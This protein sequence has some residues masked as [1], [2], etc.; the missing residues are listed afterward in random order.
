MPLTVSGSTAYPLWEPGERRVMYLRFEQDGFS[1]RSVL[2]DGGGGDEEVF[3]Y[4]RAR[5]VT[6]FAPEGQ[7]GVMYEVNPTTNRDIW[8]WS[9]TDEPQVLFNSMFNERAPVISPDGKYF[10]YISDR[11]GQD[12]IYVTSFPDAKGR[13]L[14]SSDGGTEP[15]WSPDGAELYYRVLDRLMAVPILSGEPFDLGEPVEL[16]RGSFAR[17]PFGNA[18]YDVAPDGKRFLM[19]PGPPSTQNSL[20]VV[21]NW[22]AELEDQTSSN[23]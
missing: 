4:S 12:E 7:S 20:M 2:A 18:N 19:V 15:R 11:S 22:T 5:L 14:A 1:W 10:A 9:E 17:D 16:F 21:L 13:L 8:L 6:S 23:Q 3:A